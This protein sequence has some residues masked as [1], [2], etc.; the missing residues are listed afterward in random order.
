MYDSVLDAITRLD[1]ELNY[2]VKYGKHRRKLFK[3]TINGTVT[4]GHPTRT[5]F[6]NTLRVSLYYQYLFDR[7][8][9]TNYS[10]FVGGDDFFAIVNDKDLPSIR[11][12]VAKLFSAKKYGIHGLGQCT[13]KI[14]ELGLN[15]DFLSKLGCIRPGYAYLHRQAQRIG[16]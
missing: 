3:A 5:T 16:V 7:E 1:T 13:R 11:R 10:M 15:V 8:G 12:G 4:S 9:V 6:G 14:N 2:Y